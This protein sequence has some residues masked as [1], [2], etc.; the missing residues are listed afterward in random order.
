MAATAQ[1]RIRE[2]YNVSPLML[3]ST[4]SGPA[5]RLLAAALFCALCGCG[6]PKPT[7]TQ[8]AHFR[9]VAREAGLVFQHFNGATGKFYMPEIVG[10]GAALFDYD[11]DGDLDLLIVQGDYVVPPAF[12]EHALLPPPA[13][14][15]S[16][17][18]RNDVIPG[19]KLHF[20]DVTEESGLHLEGAG[21]GVATGDIDNDGDLDLYVT[22]YGTSRLYRNDGGGRFTDITA[23][24]GTA[25]KGWSTSAV[26][27][28][29]DRDGLQDL[30]VTSYVNFSPANHKQCKGPSD[31]T[32]YCG[33]DVYDGLPSRLFHNLGG[34]RFEDVTEKSGIGAAASSG[35]GVT[36]VDLNGDGWLDLYVA[37]DGRPNHLWL[38]RQNGTFSESAMELGAALPETGK[39]RAGMGVAAADINGDGKPDL[40]I[41]NL[42]NEGASLYE[43]R[44]TVGFA[45]VS[46]A[47]GLS[48]ATVAF[49]GFGAGWFDSLNS[50]RLDLFIANGAVKIEGGQ[51]GG[52]YPYNQ[53]N[54]LLRSAGD[55]AHFE[56]VTAEAGE[57]LRY[58]EISRGAAFGDLD[59]D[60]RVDIVVTNNAGP[61]RLLRNE[62]G[63]GNH[64][65]TIRVDGGPSNRFG[66]G[67]ALEL[68][69]GTRPPLRRVVHT[70]YGYLTAS[71]ARVHF[72]LGADAG[73]VTL[74]IRWPDGAGESWVFPDTDRIVTIRRGSGSPEK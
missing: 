34:G 47:R 12:G 1:I 25:V 14:P 60:G 63:S 46:E 44:G 64:W 31:E 41:T 42:T 68:R 52:P 32:D 3:N 7:Q 27:F 43:N 62:S 37:N 45:E 16:R 20:T 53:R 2:Y 48:K 65:L 59:N 17:L 33:P 15:G 40:L 51:R 24:S 69:R 61:I 26:F 74:L 39:A 9:D 29:Y 67:A 35:L 36:A 50:G 18:Y 73:P 5:H 58:S 56:D 6:T 8:A 13:K 19:G 57:G 21:M 66:Y 4:L 30:F 71:D 28:D 11:N 55:P 70:A 10:S 72:G 54:L 23:A 38:N 22:Y 49:T